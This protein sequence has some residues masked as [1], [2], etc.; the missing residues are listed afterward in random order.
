MV[1]QNKALMCVLKV[2]INKQY[3]GIMRAI[4]SENWSLK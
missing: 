1:M 2:L 4:N 3:S